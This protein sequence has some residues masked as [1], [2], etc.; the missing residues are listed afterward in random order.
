MSAPPRKSNQHNNNIPNKI[1]CFKLEIFFFVAWAASQST[2]YANDSLPHMRG[3]VAALQQSLSDHE[4]YR[5]SV[6]SQTS[7]VS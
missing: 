4:T 5:K 2:A 1:V 3:K 7:V 6:F